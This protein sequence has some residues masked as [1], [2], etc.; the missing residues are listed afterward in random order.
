LF[1]NEN[2][3]LKELQN[4]FIDAFKNAMSGNVNTIC[5]SIFDQLIVFRKTSFS[6]IP[7]L[8]AGNGWYKFGFVE[9]DIIAFNLTITTNS[10][11]THLTNYTDDNKLEDQTYLIKMRLR[12]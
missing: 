6:D 1:D 4:D 10:S 3:V 7:E 11:Q 9:N 8:E 12:N 5:N 2:D